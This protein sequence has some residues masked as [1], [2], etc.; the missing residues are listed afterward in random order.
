MTDKEKAVREIVK[1]I[2]LK[3]VYKLWGVYFTDYKTAARYLSGDTRYK[4]HH[5]YND[6]Y[7]TF[8]RLR[9]IIDENLDIIGSKKVK[10]DLQ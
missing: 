6:F 4:I 1:Y 5:R 3:Q 8:S 10:K 2:N 9:D 7:N